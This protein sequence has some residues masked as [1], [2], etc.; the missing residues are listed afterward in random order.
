MTDD[1]LLLK[2]HLIFFP[3]WFKCLYLPIA[4]LHGVV[5][6]AYF[7]SGLINFVGTPIP[8]RA[9][10]AKLIRFLYFFGEWSRFLWRGRFFS[11]QWHAWFDFPRLS[12]LPPNIPPIGRR[13]S[14]KSV[15]SFIGYT[16]ELIWS[17]PAGLS[18]DLQLVHHGVLFLVAR[19]TD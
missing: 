3:V 18:L 16:C 5:P 7:F 17:K 19:L 6:Y 9:P 11:F 14:H 15:V 4:R 8:I 2:T 13:N 1:R 10:D 12:V